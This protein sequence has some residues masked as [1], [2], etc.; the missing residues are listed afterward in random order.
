MREGEGVDS[1]IER[2]ESILLQLGAQ[3]PPQD[4]P[5]ALRMQWLVNGLPSDFVKVVDDFDR[6][7]Y[8]SIDDLTEAILKEADVLKD[9]MAG[10]GS[11]GDTAAAAAGGGERPSKGQK[12]R[13]R[14]AAKK[15]AALAAMTAG[16]DPSVTDTAAAAH[17]GNGPT[18]TSTDSLREN[19]EKRKGKGKGKSSAS[20]PHAGLQCFRCWGFGHISRDCPTVAADSNAAAARGIDTRQWCPFHNSWQNHSPAMCIYNPQGPN[21]RGA[22]GS[23]GKGKGPGYGRGGG[24]GKGFS[25]YPSNYS[26]SYGKG[27]GYGRG[28]AAVSEG[29]WGPEPNVY[30]SLQATPH[31]VF[32]D[33][34]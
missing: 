16:A 27:R 32:L 20:N 13:R 12:Y 10:N 3:D 18:G 33:A 19:G 9:K 25:T 6:E 30:D 14:K 5:E 24:A 21:F 26:P 31:T 29:A 28:Y 2:F 7:T 15:A 22:K 4:F 8:G 17:A 34:E 1:Y 23:Y 11:G